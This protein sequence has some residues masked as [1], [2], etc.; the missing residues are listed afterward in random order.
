MYIVFPERLSICHI[1]FPLELGE[2]E[3]LILD[4]S[5]VCQKEIVL[6]RYKIKAAIGLGR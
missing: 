6:N 3:Y 5:Q 4:F 2:G 1:V